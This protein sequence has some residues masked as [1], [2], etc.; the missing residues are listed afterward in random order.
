MSG[1]TGHKPLYLVAKS[2]SPL[3]VLLDG[4]SLRVAQPNRCDGRYP[5][6]QISR[7][8]SSGPVQWESGALYSIMEQ[9][10]TITFATRTKG[11]RGV[12]IPN[13]SRQVSSGQQ[14]EELLDQ[15]NGW[16]RLEEWSTSAHRK[17]ILELQKRLPFLLRDLR[18]GQVHQQLREHGR[19]LLDPQVVKQIRKLLQG[20]S[21]A[22]VAEKMVEEEIGNCNLKTLHFNLPNIDLNQLFTEIISWDLEIVIHQTQKGLSRRYG[23]RVTLQHPAAVPLLLRA[24][25]QRQPRIEQITRQTLISYK[26]W[27]SRMVQEPG[28]SQQS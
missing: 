24:F 16:V 18:K 15:Q 8:L 7:I 2:N 9:G 22:V 26:N 14:L 4:P 21:S 28:W 12:L 17:A 25:Q 5:L 19:P 20:W 6:R 11:R 13:T 3:H 23:S 27:I 1:G 10:I